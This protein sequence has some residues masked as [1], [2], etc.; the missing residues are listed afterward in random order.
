VI[1]HLVMMIAVLAGLVGTTGCPDADDD[2]V[3]NDDDN[4]PADPNPSQDDSDG[5]GIGD[6]CDSCPDV[7]HCEPGTCLPGM[8]CGDCPCNYGFD[9]CCGRPGREGD[10]CQNTISGFHWPCDEGFVCEIIGF[11]EW[12][13]CHEAGGPD[14]PCLPGGECDEG[15]F[16]V[17]FLVVYGRSGNIYRS[18][19]APAGGLDQACLP[20]HECNEGLVCV[21]NWDSYGL[22]AWICRRE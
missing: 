8:V 4:C 20:G 15:L 5:D 14:Q 3:P 9:T 1:W 17:P 7:A 19:C 2:G 6:V 11:N 13:Y 21:E 16:C 22:P 12:G 18:M 10:T